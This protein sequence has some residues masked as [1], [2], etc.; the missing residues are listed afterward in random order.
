MVVGSSP[1]QEG[2]AEKA[3]SGRAGP[4]PHSAKEGVAR[5][6]K[7][8]HMQALR[9]GQGVDKPPWEHK[10][11]EGKPRRSVSVENTYMVWVTGIGSQPRRM[12]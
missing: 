5:V 1:P 3:G 10:G 12:G 4:F 11:R 6:C 2:R 9:S 7:W 8:Q